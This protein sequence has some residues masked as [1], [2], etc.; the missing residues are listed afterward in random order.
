MAGRNG[1]KFLRRH[2]DRRENLCVL[3]VSAVESSVALSRLKWIRS[4][5]KSLRA[6][7][8][9]SKSSNPGTQDEKSGSKSG[10]D[11]AGRKSGIE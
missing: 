10:I 7:T 3:C 5:A 11:I 4:K 8:G 6:V 2:R 1:R 9:L